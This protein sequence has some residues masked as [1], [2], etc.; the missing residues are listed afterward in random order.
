[1]EIKVLGPGCPN[2]MELERRVKE[3]LKELG[4]AANVTK[5]ADIAEIGKYIMMIPGLVINEKVKH[6]GKPLPKPEQI[7]AWIEEEKN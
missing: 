6:S 2:C 5:V 7:K 4:V 3:A 1:M